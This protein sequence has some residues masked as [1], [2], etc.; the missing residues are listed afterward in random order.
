[1]T[2]FK[3]NGKGLNRKLGLKPGERANAPLPLVIFQQFITL[4]TKKK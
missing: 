1:M 2:K 4:L 3:T